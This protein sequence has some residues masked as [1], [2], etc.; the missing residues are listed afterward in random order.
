MRNTIYTIIFSA[1][2]LFTLSGCLSNVPAGHQGVLVNKLGSDKGVDL[3]TV[4]PG[5]YFLTINEELYL[6]PTFT[7]NYTWTREIVDGDPTNE[8]FT[9]QTK[10]GMEVTCDIGISYHIEIDKISFIFQKYRKGVEEITDIYLRNMVRD[11]LVA[12]ASMLPVEAVYG[13]GKADLIAK[14]QKSVTDQCKEIGIVVENIYLIGS[15]RLPPQVIEALNSKISATQKSEQRENEIREARA[16][17]EKVKVAADGDAQAILIRAKAQA[18]AN[19]VL[20]DSLTKEFVVYQTVQRWDGVLP[21]VSSGSG[22]N[23]LITPDL[24]ENKK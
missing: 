10:E 2:A 4:G 18:E 3:K 20:A 9:I 14:A 21:K 16:A 24:T 13:S 12:E 22:M 11:A 1:I 6:F 7:Q 8:E 19:K 5:R 17:A 23:L 15:F